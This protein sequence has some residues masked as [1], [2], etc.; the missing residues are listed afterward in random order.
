[1][2]LL[3]YVGVTIPGYVLVIMSGE[4]SVADW[5]RCGN[6]NSAGQCLRCVV[7]LDNVSIV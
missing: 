4:S 6:Y 3:A 1:M 2:H 5:D 7:E